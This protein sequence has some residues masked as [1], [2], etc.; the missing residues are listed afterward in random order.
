M[1]KLP[2]RLVEVPGHTADAWVLLRDIIPDTMVLYGGT[3]IAV[4]LHHRVSRDLDF[5]FDD[6]GV[7]LAE[8]RASVARVRPTKVT[9]HTDDTLNLLFGQT[10]VQ[11]RSATGQRPVEPS[12]IVEGLRVA[13]LRDLGATKMKVVGDRGELRDYFDI[14]MIEKRTPIRAEQMLADYLSRYGDTNENNLVH[15]VTALGYL[16]D[17]A[18]DPGLPVRRTLIE[19]YWAQRQPQLVMALDSSGLPRAESELAM[20]A[21]PPGEPRSTSGYVQVPAH[22]RAGR[23][24]RGYRRRR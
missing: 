3:A 17:V 9:T 10:K 24:V 16:G 13:G 5:F 8:L 11:F 23:P 4:H 12:T 6:P 7:D 22:K 19:K 2:A 21:E 18:D 20:L 15:I 1:P 14:M